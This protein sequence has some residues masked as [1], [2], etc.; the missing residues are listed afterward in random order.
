MIRRARYQCSVSGKLYCP[1]DEALDLPTG[2]DDDQFIAAGVGLE[3]T[4]GLSRTPETIARA[5]RCACDRHQS[6]RPGQMCRA[7]LS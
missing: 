2:D 4:D 3:H 7:D 1:V 5:T 6:G